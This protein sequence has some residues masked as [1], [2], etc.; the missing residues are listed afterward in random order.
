M[1]S[2]LY[3]LNRLHDSIAIF[4]LADDGTP[5]LPDRP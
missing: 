1:G 2:Y 4:A 5:K 3:A